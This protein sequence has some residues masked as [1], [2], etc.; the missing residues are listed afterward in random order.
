M[1][2]KAGYLRRNERTINRTI[3]ALIKQQEKI[4]KSGYEEF[5]QSALDYLIEVHNA[6]D[7]HV[8]ENDTLA[9]GIIHDGKMI[10]VWGHGG[11]ETVPWKKATEIIRNLVPTLP[12]EGWVGILLSGMTGWYNVDKEMGHLGE[13]LVWAQDSFEKFFKPIK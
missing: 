11:P 1:A 13:T 9:C 12:D 7:H 8:N 5:M 4:I 3:D 6:S 10:K 2:T